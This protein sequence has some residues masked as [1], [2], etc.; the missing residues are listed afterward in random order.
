VPLFP[1]FLAGDEEVFLF[2][3]EDFFFAAFRL[4]LGEEEVELD[5]VLDPALVVGFGD[6]LFFDLL[7]DFAFGFG[8]ADLEVDFDFDFVFLAGER[9]R[10]LDLDLDFV[11]AFFLREGLVLDRPRRTGEVDFG[12]PRLVVPT[13]P[14]FFEFFVVLFGLFVVFRF[15]GDRERRSSV[16]SCFRCSFPSSVSLYE[17]RT[18]FNEFL[19]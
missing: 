1:V 19:F 11:S 17:A 12:L 3:E 9:D 16:T 10:D 6:L 7:F 4:G 14:A 2:G 8:E 13:V 18:F 5:R 15:A